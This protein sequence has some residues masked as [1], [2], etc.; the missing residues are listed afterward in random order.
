MCLGRST[1][2]RISTRS[3]IRGSG[4]GRRRRGAGGDAWYGQVY[5]YAYALYDHI[6]VHV[7]A[8]AH[9]VVCYVHCAMV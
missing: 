3:S 4:G 8:R 7:H 2:T 6:N 1:S 9:G 5:A